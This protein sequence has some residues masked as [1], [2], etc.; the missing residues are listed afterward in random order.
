MPTTLSSVT[1]T[2]ARKLYY[3]S[4]EDANRARKRLLASHLSDPHVRAYE[5]PTCNGYHLGH[6]S[7]SQLRAQKEV[8]MLDAAPTTDVTPLVINGP[9]STPNTLLTDSITT[10]PDGFVLLARAQLAHMEAELLEWEPRIARIKAQ[11][12]HLKAFLAACD[13]PLPPD[14]YVRVEV[15]AEAL[16]PTPG[17]INA[18]STTDCI[19][20]ILRHASRPLSTLEIAETLRSQGIGAQ[21]KNSRSTVSGF[22]NSPRFR[23]VGKGL[24]IVKEA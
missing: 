21:W 4:R 24:Y 23:R 13:K 3:A 20:K 22:L 6:P 18:S 12:P 2:C 11:I 9:A 14:D 7:P 15:P 10:T 8:R 17:T 16:Q 19:E 5:C 1:D